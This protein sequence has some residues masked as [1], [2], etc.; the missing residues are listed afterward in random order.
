MTAIKKN[1]KAGEPM[2][3][4]AQIVH[5]LCQK[6]HTRCPYQIA[7]ALGIEIL[8]YPFNSINGMALQNGEDIIITIKDGLTPEEEKYILA[9]E[10]GHILLH[11]GSYFA[12][13]SY[14]DFLPQKFEK[15]ADLFAAYLLVDENPEEGESLQAFSRRKG[16]PGFLLELLYA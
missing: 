3:R 12:A 15:Q 1:K 11:P 5:K 8:R 6:H 14:T 10:L 7:E 13:R 9:H 16:I 2:H 4:I